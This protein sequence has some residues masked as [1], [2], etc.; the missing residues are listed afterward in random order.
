MKKQILIGS[1]IAAGVLLAGYL[2]M[3]GYF[4]SHY[5][6]N[7]TIGD[8]SCGGKTARYVVDTNTKKAAGYLLLVKDRKDNNYNI[9]GSDFNYQYVSS[10][11]EVSILKKQNAFAW[12]L[13]IWRKSNYELKATASYDTVA[14]D[15]IISSMNL[16]NPEYI[17]EPQNAY[18][19]ITAENY[20]VVDEV[21]GISPIKEKVSEE[22][23][24]AV[25]NQLDSIKLSD[26]CYEKPEITKDNDIIKSTISQLDSYTNSTIHYQIENV[27]EN[28]SKTD[29]LKMLKVEDD[30]NVTLLEDKVK[31][32][33]QQLAYKY[34]T[35]GDARNFATSSG[36][37]ISVAGGDY[38]WVINKKKEAEQIIS[39][40]KGGKP[41]EREPV[42]EQT[43][44]Q[45][46]PDDIG[47]T[48][49]E[50]DY[51]KQHLWYYK[52]GQLMLESD[53]VSGNINASNGSVDGVY[54]IVYKQKDATLVG[55]NYASDVK[56]FMP[57]AYNIGIHDAGWR[58]SFGGE[59]YK[60]SGSHG[61]VNAPFETAR[62]LYEMVE[63]GTPVVAYY[64][65]P[66]VLTNNAAKQSN[67]YSYQA[68]PEPSTQTPA[69][70]PAN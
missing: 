16:F 39:D 40:L 54:K 6:W 7:T 19:D 28:L 22:I 25:N 64:R 43:A 47:N 69:S 70:V 67:A 60:T 23:V 59:I 66:V 14:L 24:D 44:K 37:A 36:D 12:P 68:P 1:G 31:D 56:Y 50:I 2:G 4:T 32:Y 18:I 26:N 21:E 33:V 57:F 27:D 8:L 38:G 5:L 53:I 3:A 55:E 63:V 11:E 29:I 35:Y 17:E 30:G 45:S 34:N 9:I 42:Y 20:T 10:G 58:S 52:D 65:E 13:S 46:G 62:A 49:I 51:T 61:C 41:V 48:Y 15:N